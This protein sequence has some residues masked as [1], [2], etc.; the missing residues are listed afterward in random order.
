MAMNELP[1][2]RAFTLLQLLVAVTIICLLFGLV[3]PAVQ[4]AREAGRRRQCTNN[5][6]QLALAIHEFHD[7]HNFL[8]PICTERLT[9]AANDANYSAVVNGWGWSW[10]ALTIPYWQS[11]PFSSQINWNGQQRVPYSGSNVQVVNIV[12]SST[13]I[14]PTRRAS[15]PLLTTGTLN[16]PGD[17]QWVGGAQPS[18]YAAV[19]ADLASGFSAVLTEPV[20]SRDDAANPRL[21]LRSKTTLASI[22]GTAAM[23]GEKYMKQDWLGDMAYEAPAAVGHAL[24]PRGNVRYLIE[25]QAAPSGNGATG[26]LLDSFGSSHPRV[27]LF[28][29]ADASVYPHRRQ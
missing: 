4:F 24:N 17:E 14:C 1:P 3:V 26:T 18:D 28:A 5:L 10:I 19:T 29:N 20:I 12:R 23:L 27:C 7:T 9:A 21:R 15:L 8:P 22:S 6:R 13:L 11:S 25:R 2:R 16:L